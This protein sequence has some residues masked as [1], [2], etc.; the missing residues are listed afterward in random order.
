[1]PVVLPAP[2]GACNTAQAMSASVLCK[3]SRIVAMGRFFHGKPFNSIASLK[4]ICSIGQRYIN[5][6]EQFDKQ[7]FMA[8]LKLKSNH[9]Q[10]D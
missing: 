2:G 4:W 10:I 1:M 9:K 8:A 3:Q 7:G 6:K 5:A